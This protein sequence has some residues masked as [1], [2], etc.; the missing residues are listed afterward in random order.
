MVAVNIWYQN[1]NIAGPART[2]EYTSLFEDI[3][4]T[5]RFGMLDGSST[6]T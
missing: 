1:M 3:V 5:L 2:L 6:Q 4:A